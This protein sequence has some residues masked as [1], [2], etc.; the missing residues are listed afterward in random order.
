MTFK[1]FVYPSC[2]LCRGLRVSIA[3]G[4]IVVLAT[5]AYQ[6]ILLNIESNHEA[7]FT[8]SEE[9]NEDKEH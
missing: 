1:E 7:K 9:R 8:F 6:L 2:R 3:T 5:Y 4:L